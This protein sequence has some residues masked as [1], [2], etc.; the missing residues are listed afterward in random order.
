M[1]KTRSVEIKIGE[2][3]HNFVIRE[4]C[5]QLLHWASLQ[6]IEARRSNNDVDVVLA[7]MNLQQEILKKYVVEPRE[8][9]DEFLNTE[10]G[11]EYY[12]LGSMLVKEVV[13]RIKERFT[14]LDG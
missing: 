7:V 14:F 10:A 13:M 1:P 3:V 2:T 4:H 12:A 8:I 6:I 5:Y 9:T 11:E